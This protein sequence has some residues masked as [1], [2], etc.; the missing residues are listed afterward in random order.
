[1]RVSDALDKYL[2]DAQTVGLHSRKIW[3]PIEGRA[4]GTARQLTEVIDTTEVDSEVSRDRQMVDIS[5]KLDV[6][7]AFDP[8]EVVCDLMALLN[9]LDKRERLTS[10]EGEARDVHRYVTATRGT[11]EV[12]QQ[13]ATRILVMEIVDFV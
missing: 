8:G 5:A 12:I 3:K 10:E 13:P 1:M 4:Q 11:R 6:V 9:A 2:R 7:A